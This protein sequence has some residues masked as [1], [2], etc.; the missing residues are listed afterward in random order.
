MVEAGPGEADIAGLRAPDESHTMA[1]SRARKVLE[2]EFSRE[3]S[4]FSSRSV[5]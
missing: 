2:V 1:G 4:C 5:G 3:R